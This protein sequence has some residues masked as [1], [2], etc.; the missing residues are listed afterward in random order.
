MHSW[1]CTAVQGRQHNPTIP[2]IDTEAADTHTHTHT[3]TT[4][5]ENNQHTP[6]HI[7]YNS[8]QQERQGS[9]RAQRKEQGK[10]SR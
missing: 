9:R 5:E 8:Q 4:G 1:Q 3:H 10:G 6:P 7:V 2:T